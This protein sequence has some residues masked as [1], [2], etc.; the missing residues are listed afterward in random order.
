MTIFR[1]KNRVRLDSIT[2]HRLLHSGK[3]TDTCTQFQP[4][5]P[6]NVQT[7]PPPLRLLRSNRPRST[8]PYLVLVLKRLLRGRRLRRVALGSPYSLCWQWPMGGRA[9]LH[10]PVRLPGQGSRRETQGFLPIKGGV[11]VGRG[12]HDHC[13]WVEEAFWGT[14][15]TSLEELADMRIQLHESFHGAIKAEF[16]GVHRRDFT[17]HGEDG[18][19]T[20]APTKSPCS[21]PNSYFCSVVRRAPSSLHDTTTIV[22]DRPNVSALVL[23]R[24]NLYSPMEE[25]SL[26]PDPAAKS[27]PGPV[28][29]TAWCTSRRLSTATTDFGEL[30]TLETVLNG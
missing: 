22:E 5:S 15:E 2:R 20:G 10:W 26:W 8:P 21:M 11:G 6:Q 30:G 24:S 14:A 27:A 13:P 19:E 25:H 3:A 17:D 23:R 4:T 29:R 16:P 28:T 7:F 12:P 1:A 18:L 9:I